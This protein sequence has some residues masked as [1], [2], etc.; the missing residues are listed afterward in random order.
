MANLFFGG[1]KATKEEARKALIEHIA[2]NWTNRFTVDFWSDDGGHMIRAV[3]EYDD[4]TELMPIELRNKFPAKFMGW[5]LVVL[6]V[7][8]GHIDVI[9]KDKK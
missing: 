1:E 4:P 5:R 9:F 3:L 2:D 7:P 8:T 6:K